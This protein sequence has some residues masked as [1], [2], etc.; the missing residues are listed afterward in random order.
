[1]VYLREPLVASGGRLAS[2]RQVS[3]IGMHSF[4]FTAFVRTLYLVSDTFVDHA[5]MS[6]QHASLT[7]RAVL[8]L[9]VNRS[10]AA[11]SAA[12]WER[13]SQKS[14]HHRRLKTGSTLRST[15]CRALLPQD[16]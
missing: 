15:P 16:H 12:T 9:S 13:S 10:S 3:L 6:R 4:H 14:E 7:W 1:M 2:I 8:Q 11:S 5:C